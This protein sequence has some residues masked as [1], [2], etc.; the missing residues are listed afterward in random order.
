MK[1]GEIAE[2]N[3]EFENIGMNVY[4]FMQECTHMR[5]LLSF[6]IL[7]QNAVSHKCFSAAEVF[8][9]N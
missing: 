4:I 5:K 3:S 2:E 6:K 1:C 8:P 9:Q 7:V